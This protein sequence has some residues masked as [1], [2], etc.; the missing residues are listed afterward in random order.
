MG[1][2]HQ[3]VERVLV[4]GLTEPAFQ[5]SFLHVPAVCSWGSYVIIPNPIFLNWKVETVILILKVVVARRGIVCEMPS[6]LPAQKEPLV[7]VRYCY[8]IV[9]QLPWKRSVLLLELTCIKAYTLSPPTHCQIH[10]SLGAST[11]PLKQYGKGHQWLSSCWSLWYLTWW[12]TS[13]FQKHCPH[14]LSWISPFSDLSA[15]LDWILNVLLSLY[16]FFQA[17][18]PPYTHR[19]Y[20]CL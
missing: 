16:K 13:F 10:C 17:V 7:A 12:A 6:L 4:Y 11:I 9:G 20:F 8:F 2:Q 1:R 15:R 19:I 18:S 5:S 3:S 14:C